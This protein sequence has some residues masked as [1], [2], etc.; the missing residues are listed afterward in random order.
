[1]IPSAPKTALLFAGQGTQYVGMGR[2]LRRYPEA[3][4]VFQRADDALGMALS[5][6][7]FDGPEDALTL[8]AN[9]QPAVLTVALAGYA[10]LASRGFTPAAVAGHSLGEFGAL[11]AAGALQ[12]EDAVRLCRRRGE[13]MQEAVAPGVGA[14]TAVGGLGAVD[15]TPVIQDVGGICTIAA[16]NA[17]NLVVISGES[18]A[19]GEA[20]RR[21]EALSARITPIPVSAPFHSPYLRGAAEGL[22]IALSEIDIQPLRLPY[23]D[24]VSATWTTEISAPALIERLVTQVTAPV[25]WRESLQILIDQGVERFW[26]VGPGRANLSHLKRLWRKA[27]VAALDTPADLDNILTGLGTPPA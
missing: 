17:P 2:H 18:Q 22:R 13:L 16:D 7:I 5:S 25:R 26:Q 21:L 4:A 19:V 9:T 14:M 1:M 12:L 11:V 24:N 20:S 6:L 23:V 15:I 10:V 27:P 3:E 8:T